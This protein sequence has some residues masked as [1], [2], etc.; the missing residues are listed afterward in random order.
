MILG[1][2]DYYGTSVNKASRVCTLAHGGQVLITEQVYNITVKDNDVMKNSA[3]NCIGK[4]I[5]QRNLIGLLCS[6]VLRGFQEEDAIY[7]ILPK[8]LADRTFG[9]LSQDD[10]PEVQEKLQQRKAK[11]KTKKKEEEM[12]Q[13]GIVEEVSQLVKEI[14]ATLQVH[15]NTRASK[16]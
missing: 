16:D 10:H 1:R 4:C 13:E 11:S 9:K 7:Q 5:L 3:V 6:D 14:E 2:A 12:N 15:Q 8:G